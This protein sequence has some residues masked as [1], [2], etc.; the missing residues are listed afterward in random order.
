MVIEETIDGMNTGT[1]IV[2]VIVNLVEEREIIIEIGETIRTETEIITVIVA[3][4]AILVLIGIGTET[5]ILGPPDPLDIMM[6]RGTEIGH[7]TVIP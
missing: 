1:E 3:I 6:I 7:E 2:T 4:I 5:T